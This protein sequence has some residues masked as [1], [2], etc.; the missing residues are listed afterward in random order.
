MCASMHSISTWGANVLTNIVSMSFSLLED[1]VFFGGVGAFWEVV[2]MRF[3][4]VCL[5]S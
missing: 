1:S 3:C 4:E 5:L 2:W